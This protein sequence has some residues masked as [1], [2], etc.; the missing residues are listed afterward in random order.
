MQRLLVR[1]KHASEL[2]SRAQQK[3]KSTAS[4][5]SVARH[6]LQPPPEAGLLGRWLITQEEYI[7]RGIHQTECSLGQKVM[8]FETL[9]SAGDVT[10]LATYQDFSIVAPPPLKLGI[11]PYIVGYSI[12]GKIRHHNIC[13]FL[14]TP[15]YG[16]LAHVGVTIYYYPLSVR[17]T[18]DGDMMYGEIKNDSVGL[19]I[20]L[21]AVRVDDDPDMFPSE[22][23]QWK[24]N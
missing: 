22:R 19:T 10:G 15:I 6:E 7:A 3:A 12:D 9:S 4:A 2:E 24:N 11:Y 23:N 21:R 17:V 16:D 20:L 14:Q 5:R 1:H 18:W 8:T 13:E